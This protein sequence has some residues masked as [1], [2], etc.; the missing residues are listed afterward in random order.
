MT[1]ARPL[2]VKPGRFQEKAHFEVIVGNIGTCRKCG[3]V[4]DYSTVNY[5]EASET[6]KAK[7]SKGGKLHGANNST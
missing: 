5:D 6:T 3:Q 7:A 4:R 1:F 2:I